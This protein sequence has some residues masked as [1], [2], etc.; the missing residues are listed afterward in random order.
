MPYTPYTL[1]TLS[2]REQF[3]KPMGTGRITGAYIP[4]R[5][6]N[7]NERPYLPREEETPEEVLDRG[8]TTEPFH[9]P[10]SRGIP[11]A[12]P[13]EQEL[14]KIEKRRART[15]LRIMPRQEEAL[16]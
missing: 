5:T 4:P 13:E 3:Y 12:A 10:T 6:R 7:W 14:H 11:A 8:E 16:Q 15:R 9:E 2:T 1:N